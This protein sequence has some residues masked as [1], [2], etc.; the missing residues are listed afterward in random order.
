LKTS[1]K[2]NGEKKFCNGKFKLLL[3]APFQF[4]SPSGKPSLKTQKQKTDGKKKA[5][6]N[7]VCETRKKGEQVNKT[8]RD[9]K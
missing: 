2:R 4:S 3:A 1:R 5:K 7:F 6:E 8:N 9:W